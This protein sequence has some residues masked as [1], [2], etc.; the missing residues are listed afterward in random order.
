MKTLKDRSLLMLKLL[1]AGYIIGAPSVLWMTGE[2]AALYL[3]FTAFSLLAA[4]R[5]FVNG[6]MWVSPLHFSM[7][8]LFIYAAV[9]S[10]FAKNAEGNLLYIYSIALAVVFVTVFFDYLRENTQESIGRRLLY[11]LFSSGA[12]VCCVNFIYW[13]FV[14]LPV[15]DKFLFKL[16]LGNNDLLAIFIFTGMW[17]AVILFKGASNAVKRI[18][19]I[20]LIPML[21]A[22]II[23][24]S[25]VSYVFAAIMTVGFLVY[26]KAGIAFV[27]AAVLSISVFFAVLYCFFDTAAFKDAFLC[28]IHKPFGVGGGGFLSGQEMYA[29]E[30]YDE[31]KRLGI[32][33]NVA[34]SSGVFGLIILLILFL[35]EMYLLIKKQFFFSFVSVLVF[36]A[37]LFVPFT[38]AAAIL[39]SAGTMAY[40]E[41]ICDGYFPVHFKE[42][43]KV[44]FCVALSAA[45]I[46]SATLMCHGLIRMNAD[47]Q[48]QN[49]NIG[50]AQELY[51]IAS[52]INITDAKSCRGVVSCMLDMGLSD[53]QNALEY[54]V[55]AGKREKN[56]VSNMVQ[57][58][59]IMHK[60]GRYKE[61]SQMW[62]EVIL[63]APYNDNYKVMFA[64]TLYEIV[65]SNE[66]GS[67][68]TKDAYREIVKVSEKTADLGAKKEINDLADKAQEFNKGVFFNEG[69]AVD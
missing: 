45:G 25:A 4:L 5:F 3:T 7:T 68:E 37:V 69:E 8:A 23:A 27:P 11:M 6:K 40:N 43:K 2:L 56:N 10:V 31:V 55:R 29:S 49:E 17:S 66:K 61:S 33:A 26:K 22:W 54:S 13:F 35:R 15:G 60:A 36:C 12:A 57:S 53:E 20:L 41:F 32:L 42:N 39:F 64:Q 47:R 38:G 50:K 52:N 21:A 51:T 18:F 62:K 16:G 58:A 34:S 63:K 28:G 24:S 30:F 9:M 59:L 19:V 48:Y 65:Q 46:I 14:T 1:M 67:K 44:R